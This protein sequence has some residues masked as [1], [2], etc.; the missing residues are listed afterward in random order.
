MPALYDRRSGLD[1]PPVAALHVEPVVV[2]RRL[3][4]LLLLANLAGCA[5][6]PLL[7]PTLLQAQADRQAREGAWEQAVATYDEFL[8]RYPADGAV[9]RVRASRDTLAAMVT[10][11][12]ELRR[13]RE[14]VAQ[15]RDELAR[16]SAEEA[17]LRED[18]GRL[19]GEA[20]ELRDEVVRLRDERVRLR[21]AD[22]QLRE[23]LSRRD[24]DL[25][26]ARQELATQRQELAAQQAEAERLRSDIE[27]LKDIDLKLERKR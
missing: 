15:L 17:R 13:R 19:R 16:L 27:R 22:S 4:V 24:N 12:A 3:A 23:Q 21:A 25:A 5:S 26:R 20:T 11:H 18:R 9:P 14:E 7:G 1:S 6:V 10:A 8:R 2:V